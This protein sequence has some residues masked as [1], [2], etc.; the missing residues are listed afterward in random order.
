MES[1]PPWQPW[2]RYEEVQ[3]LYDE[4]R[5]KKFEPNAATLAAVKNSKRR[6]NKAAGD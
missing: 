1:V 3:R 4:M 5:S 6:R 2:H